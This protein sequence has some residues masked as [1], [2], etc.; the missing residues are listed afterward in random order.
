MDAINDELYAHPRPEHERMWQLWHE[1]GELTAQ[2]W[3]LRYDQARE[4]RR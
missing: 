4:A 1:R 3:R 2:V